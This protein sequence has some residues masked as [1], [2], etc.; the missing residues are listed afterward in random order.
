[1]TSKNFRPTI[2]FMQKTSFY[3]WPKVSAGPGL[4]VVCLSSRPWSCNYTRRVLFLWILLSNRKKPQQ[5]RA[6]KISRGACMGEKKHYKRVCVC[7]SLRAQERN[8]PAYLPHAGESKREKSTRCFSK[9]DKFMTD[10]KL[11]LLCRK[12]SC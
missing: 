3:Y 8:S 9:V 6:V 5:L 7:C 12:L 1:L 2:H 4:F 11:F 10:I